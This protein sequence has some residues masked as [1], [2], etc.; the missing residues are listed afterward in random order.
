M[1]ETQS[2]L[3]PG[4]IVD[5]YQVLGVAGAGG[6]G[7]VYK[8]FDQKLER[9]VALKF[10]PASMIF[11]TKGKERFQGPSLF[12]GKPGCKTLRPIAYTVTRRGRGWFLIP[13]P[14]ISGP[15]SR[16]STEV[17]SRVGSVI[18]GQTRFS[19]SA[20]KDIHGI[21]SQ[22]ESLP[23][24]RSCNSGSQREARCGKHLPPK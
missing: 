8:A 1:A 3:S 2:T 15:V 19:I 24:I 16:D 14:T 13:G 18:Q 22:M 23:F 17:W 21:C 9:M 12:Q 10:L 20:S 7:V 11:S 4:E 5:H 6:M